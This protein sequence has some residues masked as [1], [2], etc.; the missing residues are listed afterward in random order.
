MKPRQ[1]VLD[2]ATNSKNMN[3]TFRMSKSLLVFDGKHPRSY[4][5]IPGHELAYSSHVG[6][7][8]APLHIDVTAVDELVFDLADLTTT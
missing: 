8:F 5:G 1:Q 3:I 2:L 7:L 6:Q 4:H